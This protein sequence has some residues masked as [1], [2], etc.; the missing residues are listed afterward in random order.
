[1][2]TSNITPVMATAMTFKS[3]LFNNYRN[4][5]ILG[6]AAIVIIIQFGIFKYFYPYASYIFGDSFVYLK[7]AYDN[8][9]INFYLVGYS[10]FLRLF[11][12]FSGSDVLLT[13]FQYIL[14]QAS[15]LYLLFTLF[16]FYSVSKVTQVILLCFAVFNPLFLYLANLISSDGLFLALSLAWFGLLIHMLHQP[17]VRI[18]SWHAL[19]LFAAFTVRYNAF[20]YPAIA[21]AAFIL[22]KQSVP[23]KLFGWAAGCILCAFFVFYTAGKYQ[24]LTGTWQYSPF[25]GWLI[26]NNAMYS[27]RYVP[28]SQRKQVPAQ[29]QQLDKSIRAYFDSTRDTKRYPVET[30]IA[31]TFYMWDRGLPLYAFMNN[32][33][34]K[35]TASTD[36]QRWAS[37]GPFY[38]EYGAFIIKEYPLYYVRHFLWP[39]AIRYYAPPVEYLSPYNLGGDAVDS[40]AQ[41]WFGYKSLRLKARIKSS[42]EVLLDIYPILA[43]IVN[44]V[45]VFSLVFFLL[46]NGK[47]NEGYFYQAVLLVGALWLL[48]SGFTIFTSPVALRFQIFP[49]I[50]TTIFTVLLMDWVV[51]KAI[52][53]EAQE[54]MYST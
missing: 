11:S 4:K 30:T 41:R 24:A 1:M 18:V 17:C 6:I 13:G 23:R 33:Y 34:K 29:F 8:L 44:L 3:Y 27:Y 42:N 51:G 31:S 5:I 26:A 49:I 22:S 14:I 21:A 15:A 50:L 20:I 40:I 37:M 46:L 25:G 54:K 47:K 39:N 36:L 2:H 38:K 7:T 35:D 12:V 43:G 53:V 19:L 32:M 9:D 48:N 16:Y 52:Q 10:R 45:F 28:S